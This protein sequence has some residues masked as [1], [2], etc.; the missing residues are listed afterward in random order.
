ML[1]RLKE[2]NKNTKSISAFSICDDVLL[3]TDRV[4]MPLQLQKKILKVSFWA[5]RN[6]TDEELDVKL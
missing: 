2:R 1:V 5:S 6:F 3:Y 4:V